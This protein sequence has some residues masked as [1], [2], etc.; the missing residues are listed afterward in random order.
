[1]ISPVSA[2]LKG[3]HN[4][5][6]KKLAVV[7]AVLLV[8]STPAVVSAASQSAAPEVEAFAGWAGFVD[9]AT[10]HHTAAGAAARFYVTPRLGIGPE[11]AYM[12]G[13]DD[14]RDVLLTGNLT[15]D[16]FPMRGPEARSVSPFFVVGGG[17]YQYR[18]T[19]P[20]G[21][22]TASD[23]AFT[24]GGGIRAWMND[25]ICVAGDVRVGWELHLRTGVVV[26]FRLGD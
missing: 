26:G 5:I 19:L 4:G 24:A 13:P 16:V 11:F 7:A 18:D 20:T 25:R 12:W 17:W 23:P 6:R 2:T 10:I 9:D 22:F 21:A 3:V 1:M 15:F 14:D 8:P